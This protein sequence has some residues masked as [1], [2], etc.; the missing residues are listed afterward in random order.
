MSESRSVSFSGSGP[1]ET[2]LDAEPADA[3]AA[4]DEAL[5]SDPGRPP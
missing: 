1:P 3:L 2:V 4:L 5:A